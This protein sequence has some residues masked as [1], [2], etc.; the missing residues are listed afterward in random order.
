[1]GSGEK[2]LG[3]GV[4]ALTEP[5]DDESAAESGQHRIY[6]KSA[7]HPLTISCCSAATRGKCLSRE[8]R[9]PQ[10]E[11]VKKNM[12]IESLESICESFARRLARLLRG[13]DTEPVDERDFGCFDAVWSALRTAHRHRRNRVVR[14]ALRAIEAGAT[15]FSKYPF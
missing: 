13:G 15:E 14:P 7:H 12:V 4:P 11:S 3:F 2:D 9:K 1:L 8:V 10:I 6:H 5:L